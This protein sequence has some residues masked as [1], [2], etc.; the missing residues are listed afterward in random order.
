MWEQIVEVPQLKN[1]ER[2]GEPD[3]P[4]GRKTTENHQ[5]WVK[6]SSY[7]SRAQQLVWT[8]CELGPCSVWLALGVQKPQGWEN[9]WSYPSV[10]HKIR[11]G[12]GRVTACPQAPPVGLKRNQTCYILREL[13]RALEK[14]FCRCACTSVP[15]RGLNPTSILWQLC[16]PPRDHLLWK[17][18][19]LSPTS[20][21][22]FFLK[23]KKSV[24]IF[25]LL[26]EIENSQ[27]PRKLK[28]ELT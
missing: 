26:T 18:Q 2:W 16:L 6:A 23:K 15:C 28:S 10:G 8:S 25:I 12:L 24:V 4:H 22:T 7:A 14:A 9:G 19:V 13:C 20:S 11:T 27:W 1:W 5:R 3:S 17:L 21:F